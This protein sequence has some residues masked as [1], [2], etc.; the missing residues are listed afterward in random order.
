MKLTARFAA[1]VLVL[2]LGIGIPAAAGWFVSRTPETENSP[3]Q[4]CS[5]LY[6]SFAIQTWD[7]CNIPPTSDHSD[8]LFRIRATFENDAGDTTLGL[9]DTECRRAVRAGLARPLSA[10]V[11]TQK[12]LVMH[13]GLG[14]WYD[15]AVS[16]TVLGY[17]GLIENP[18]SYHRS[19][20]GFNIECLERVEPIGST[21]RGRINYAQ[22]RLLV[23]LG[24]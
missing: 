7:I 12:M 19:R 9:G 10:C 18:K 5:S 24:I 23:A 15:G 6:S 3:C 2:L 11:G 17:F 20:E 21:L 14:T 13:S 1:A 22:E 16:V 8:R 4:S